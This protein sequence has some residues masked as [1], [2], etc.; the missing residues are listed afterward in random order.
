MKTNRIAFLIIAAFLVVSCA[1]HYQRT[2]LFQEKLSNGELDKASAILEK[3]KQ[4]KKNKNRLLYLMNKGYLNHLMSDYTESNTLFNEA[5]LLMEDQRKD[6]GSEALAL[7]SNPEVKPYKAEDFERVL[8]N[9]YKALNYIELGSYDDAVVECKRINLLLQQLNDKYSKKKNKYS[10]DAFAHIVMGLIYDA[11]KNYNDA[12]IAYRNAFEVFQRDGSGS[13]M[14]TLVPEQLKKDLLRTAY[15]IGF[16]DEQMFY[17]KQFGYKYIHEENP[18]GDLVFF[19][20]NGLGP[21]KDDWSINFT[22]VKGAAGNLFFENEELDLSF[23]FPATSTNGNGNFGDLSVIR[24]AFPK[25]LERKPFYNKG[26]VEHSGKTYAL[27]EA[28]NINNIAFECL[29]DRFLREMANSLLRLAIKKSS[30]AALRDKNKE[31]GALLSVVNA[32][33]EK[34]DTRNWQTLPYSISYTRVPLQKGDNAVYLNKIRGNEQDQDEFHFQGKQGQT[35]F[36]LHH[37]LESM[38]LSSEVRG[39]YN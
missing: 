33:T 2:L 14:G 23:T 1:S 21:V 38:P 11:R 32:V 29:N 7:I 19:W 16:Y 22:L 5:D 9:Y 25:Y 26:A 36:F 34:A 17:E 37:S 8:V 39:Y 35:Q 3:D 20:E 31:L 10:D 27:E 30:E 18:H 4:L 13:Y 12:F 28:E 24:V 15:L 6:F